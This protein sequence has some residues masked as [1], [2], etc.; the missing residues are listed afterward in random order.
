MSLILEALK[1]SERQ[2]R[3][4]ESPSLGSPIMA[5]RRRRS[6]MPALVVLIL[7]GLAVLWWTRRGGDAPATAPEAPAQSA[8]AP[9]PAAPDATTF[10]DAVQPVPTAPAGSSR[11]IAQSSAASRLPH[12]KVP[13]DATSGLAPDLREKVRSGE[14]VVPNAKLLKPGQ[15]ATIDEAAQPVAETGDAGRPEVATPAASAPA[16][17]GPSASNAAP[18]AAQVQAQVPAPTATA[19]ATSAATAT[20]TAPAPAPAVAA[21]G[22]GI[23]LIWE[24]PYA[25]RRELPEIKLSM[26]V[27]ADQPGQR[28]VIINGDR[29][30]EGDEIDGLD[31]VEIRRDGVVFEHEGV[32][33]LYPRGG[34]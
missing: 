19:A 14:V 10:N 24:L 33:F 9:A 12:S 7:L 22:P 20:S 34:R 3:L 5:V 32:R 27:Y 18:A 4:G 15:P 23:Q 16:A 25:T 11:E 28:F 1:K 8:A 26:H 31:L 13:A 6:L 21:P 30:V 2:R 17:A 29:H